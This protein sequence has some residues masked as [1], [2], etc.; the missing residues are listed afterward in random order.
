MSPRAVLAVLAVAALALCA[1]GQQGEKDWGSMNDADFERIYQ[2]WRDNDE[3]DD[4][5]EEDPMKAPQQDLDLDL[6]SLSEEAIRREAMRGRT[7]MVYVTMVGLPSEYDT[8]VTGQRW[9]MGLLNGSIRTELFVMGKGRVIVQTGQ[10]ERAVEIKD[11]LVQQPEVWS[12]RIDGK[13][14]PGLG[15]GAG[16]SDR[17]EL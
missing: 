9:Q 8:R 16:E 10:G 5:E 6:E 2:E 1:V 13:K 15:A 12:V 4:G 11:F 3:E 7:V 17:E 14:F